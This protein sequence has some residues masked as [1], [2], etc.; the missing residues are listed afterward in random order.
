MSPAL[1]IFHCF[2]QL[3][4]NLCVLGEYLIVKP[5]I[6]ICFSCHCP[7]PSSLS[8]RSVLNVDYRWVGRCVYCQVPSRHQESLDFGHYAKLA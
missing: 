5:F 4:F 2:H 8:K 1:Q 6:I 3:S 7:R